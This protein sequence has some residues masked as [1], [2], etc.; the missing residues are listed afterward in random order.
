MLIQKKTLKT[1]LFIDIE[2]VSKTQYFHELPKSLQLLWKCKSKQFLTDRS[3]EVTEEL[4][5]KLYREKAGIFAEFGKIV[6]ISIGY[7]SNQDSPSPVLRVKSLYGEEVEILRNFNNILNEHYTDIKKDYLCGHNIKEFDIPF[8]CR[9][10]MVHGLKLPR[11]I[12]I[13]GKRSWQLKQFLD[14]MEMWKFGEFKNYTSLNLLAEILN[15]PWPNDAIDGSQISKVYWED[16]DIHRIVEYCEKDV[17]TV[18]QI[19]MRFSD[20]SLIDEANIE[21]VKDNVSAASLSD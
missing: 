2:T 14:T 1:S 6:C 9:R 18:A 4:A 13:S 15:I 19:D 16:D 3:Q 10:N 20:Q 21:I 5:A 8:I 11:L 7:L 12:N 17:T